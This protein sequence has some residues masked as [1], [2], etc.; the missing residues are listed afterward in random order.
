MRR[1]SSSCRVHYKS[2]VDCRGGEH[3]DSREEVGREAQNSQLPTSDDIEIFV[4]SCGDLVATVETIC[5]F[6]GVQTN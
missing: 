3:E 5:S 6:V 4:E 2:S 1:A